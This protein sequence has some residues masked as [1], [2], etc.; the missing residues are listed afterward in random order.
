MPIIVGQVLDRRPRAR[1]RPDTVLQY[2]LVSLQAVGSAAA[3]IHVVALESHRT[4]SADDPNWHRP[5]PYLIFL[6]TMIATA[7][8][9]TALRRP[10]RSL[11]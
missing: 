10:A 4:V 2:V 5:A 6:C 11:S 1:G 9:L 8:L 7:L 3:M